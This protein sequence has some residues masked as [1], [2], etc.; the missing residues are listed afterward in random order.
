MPNNVLKFPSARTSQALS[1]REAEVQ[2]EAYL[3]N[4]DQNHSDEFARRYL[5]DIDV[6]SALCDKLKAIG[7]NNPQKVADVAEHAY[8][9]I[10]TNG[11]LGLF[12]DQNYALGELAHLRARATRSLGRRDEAELWLC[13]AEASYRHTVH[14]TPCLAQ[15]AYTRLALRYDTGRFDEVLE[16]L[17]SVAD[18]FE[19]LGML[20]DLFKAR[21][22]QAMVM[23]VVGQTRNALI[24][25]ETLVNQPAVKADQALYGR[26]LV[27]LG[28][29]YQLENRYAEAMGVYQEALPLL[30][31]S[32]QVTATAAL[33]SV[34]AAT[35]R[36]LGR[37]YEAAQA[38]AEAKL[39][40]A[41]LGMASDV[42]YMSI[43]RA[44]ALLAADRNRE[45]EFE[46]LGAL[47]II[48]ELNLV[49][50]GLAAVAVLRESARRRKLNPEAL[51]HVG[52]QLR[53][54]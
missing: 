25:L 22:F 3:S 23:K 26:I 10:T 44:E 38:F 29:V 8:R 9:I 6:V 48:E 31:A 18:S 42:A 13:R 34:V 20:R 54:K 28:D 30:R 49:S 21:L 11:K 32:G 27:D 50:K 4:N 5:S 19:K 1:P 17:P 15:V 39:D 53:A 36:S 40:F 46:V 33:K 37:N 45:A 12:D 51:R 24:T 16:L 7:E 47:P 41:A 14:P 35:Y 52:E 2:A 43:L